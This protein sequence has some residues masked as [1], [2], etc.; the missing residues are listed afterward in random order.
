MTPP[1]WDRLHSVRDL[2]DRADAT[3]RESED[4]FASCRDAL[5]S[6]LAHQAVLAQVLDRE[7]AGGRP[8]RPA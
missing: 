1:A 8:V 6:M 4:L 2:I 3:R 5:R 7:A